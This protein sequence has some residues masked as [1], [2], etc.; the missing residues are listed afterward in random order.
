MKRSIVTVLGLAALAA[1]AANAGSPARVS[2]VQRIVAQESRGGHVARPPQTQQLS[3]V[4]RIILQDQAR[5]NDSAYSGPGPGATSVQ[6]VEA[7]GFHRGDAGIGAAVILAALLML[8]GTTVV[9]R[10]RRPGRA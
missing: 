9:V 4:E 6:I 2:P 1:P 7:G 3:P 10:S 8:A 5:A